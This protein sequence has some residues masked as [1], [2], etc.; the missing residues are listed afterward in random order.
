MKINRPCERAKNSLRWKNSILASWEIYSVSARPFS[1]NQPKER[2]AAIPRG[3]RRF[4]CAPVNPWLPDLFR[5]QRGW[6]VMRRYCW[7]NAPPEKRKF[8][9]KHR[10]IVGTF[11]GQAVLQRRVLA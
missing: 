7:A 9:R 5:K 4:S 10:T 11:Y 1:S 2:P 8:L 6:R 3:H